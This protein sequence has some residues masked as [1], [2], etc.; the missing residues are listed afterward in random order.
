MEERGGGWEMAAVLLHMSSGTF[1][2]GSAH[3]DVQLGADH[4]ALVRLGFAAEHRDTSL[5]AQP[6][7]HCWKRRIQMLLALLA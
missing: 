2:S 5:A 6:S 1:G 4:M 7:K 3:S